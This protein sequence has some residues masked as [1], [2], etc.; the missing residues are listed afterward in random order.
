M[1]HKASQL[2]TCMK[3]EPLLCIFQAVTKPKQS[4]GV[5][6]GNMKPT[7][8]NHFGLKAKENR[9]TVENGGVFQFHGMRSMAG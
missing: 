7:V 4:E 5:S 8:W 6:K 3:G 2:T 1:C 9:Q